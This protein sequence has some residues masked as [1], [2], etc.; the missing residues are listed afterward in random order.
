MGLEIE[1][2]AGSLL[3]ISVSGGS[4][5][6]EISVCVVVRKVSSGVSKEQ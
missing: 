4:V 2:D 1:E 6:V 5:I 3:W